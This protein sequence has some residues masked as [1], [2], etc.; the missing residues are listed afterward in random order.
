MGEIATGVAV[1]KIAFL[2]YVS[3]DAASP[4]AVHS[5][6]PMHIAPPAT[7]PKH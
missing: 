3:A 6:S 2:L 5:V 1:L 4:E 7:S